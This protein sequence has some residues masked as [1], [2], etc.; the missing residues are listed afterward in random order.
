MFTTKRSQT[1]LGKGI[2]TPFFAAKL[3]KYSSSAT[4]STV[5]LW[6]KYIIKETV[7]IQN[8]KLELQKK[9]FVL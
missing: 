7:I 6:K 4:D 1:P 5:E 9:I 3:L 8:I 2:W